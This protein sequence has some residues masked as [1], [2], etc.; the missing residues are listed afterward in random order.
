MSDGLE[1]DQGALQP[2]TTGRV[3]DCRSILNSAITITNLPYTLII[4]DNKA[5]NTV[6]K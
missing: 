6:D 3:T 4:G 2:I 5:L 1:R